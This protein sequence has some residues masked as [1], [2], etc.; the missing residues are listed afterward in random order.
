M[1][2]PRRGC[3]GITSSEPVKKNVLSSHK[4]KLLAQESCKG[5]LYI[6]AQGLIF[7]ESTWFSDGLRLVI[8]QSDINKFDTKRVGE[9]EVVEIGTDFGELMF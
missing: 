3:C 6:S 9:K 7:E 4:C 5:E 8:P 2:R 1:L